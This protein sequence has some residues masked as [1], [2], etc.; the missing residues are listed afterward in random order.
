M[1]VNLCKNA[2]RLLKKITL[3]LI[4]SKC[5]RISL[6][7]KLGKYKVNCGIASQTII[8]YRTSE[9]VDGQQL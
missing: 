6:S 8:M 1:S 9:L 4:E 7:M 3:Q 5:G 2:S